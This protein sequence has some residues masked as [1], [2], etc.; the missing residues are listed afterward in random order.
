MSVGYHSNGREARYQC[1]QLATTFGGPRCQSVSAQPVDEFV[2]SAPGE[3]GALITDC[4][5]NAGGEPTPG[6]PATGRGPEP[7]I[8]CPSGLVRHA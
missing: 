5:K 8:S 4:L 1:W 7:C 6:V 2:I 3:A